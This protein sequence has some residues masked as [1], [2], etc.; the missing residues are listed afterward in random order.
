MAR[1][2]VYWSS[3]TTIDIKTIN[4]VIMMAVSKA[5][6]MIVTSNIENSS[7]SVINIRSHLVPTFHIAGPKGTLTSGRLTNIKF[8]RVSPR[9]LSQCHV[10]VTTEENSLSIEHSSLR[11]RMGLLSDTASMWQEMK[12]S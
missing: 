3:M 6:P 2:R 7:K 4:R 5:I 8:N 9:Y 11:M 10:K 12:Y 1:Q